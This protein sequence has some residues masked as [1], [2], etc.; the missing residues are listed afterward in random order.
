MESILEKF[1]KNQTISIE[2][3]INNYNNNEYT[4]NYNE[5]KNKYK[6]QEEISIKT[7]TNQK[8]KEDYFNEEAIE[9][10]KHLMKIDFLMV[11]YIFLIFFTR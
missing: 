5:N 6:I 7:E 8:I 11:S 2:K 1:T 10:P 3:S 4:K 9:V